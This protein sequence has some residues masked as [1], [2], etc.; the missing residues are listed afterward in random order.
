[1]PGVAD[2]KKVA[3]RVRRWAMKNRRRWLTDESLC[4]MCAITSFRIF[5]QL[6]GAGFTDV[7]MCATEDDDHTF[8]HCDG[9]VVDVTAT[10]FDSYKHCYRAVEVLPITE[11]TDDLWQV[12]KK[13]YTVDDMR[14]H[15]A[16]WPDGQQP[17]W[18]AG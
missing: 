5:T 7:K 4:C 13:L 11:A 1:M 6:K 17:A 8:I 12:D 15:F 14:K 9:Y 10:Q 2:I 16:N 18:V 3:R